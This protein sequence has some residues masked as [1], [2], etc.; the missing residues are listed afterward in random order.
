MTNRACIEKTESEK[1]LELRAKTDRQLVNYLHSKLEAALHSEAWSG[2][3]TAAEQTLNEVEHLVFFLAEEQK[4]SLSAMLWKLRVEMDRVS[5]A[6]GS[7]S[8]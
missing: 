8:G 1:L 2:D 7:P 4:K 6:A 5:R 3:R